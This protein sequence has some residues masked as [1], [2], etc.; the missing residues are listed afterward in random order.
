LAA[1]PRWQNPVSP[2]FWNDEKVRAWTDHAQLLALYLLTCPA[3]TGEGFY[4]LRLAEAS[5]DLGWPAERTRDAL[6]ELIRTDFADYDEGPRVVLIVKGLKYHPSGFESVKRPTEGNVRAIKG[7]LKALDGVQG[8]ARLFARFHV[9]AVR[10]QP[11][12]ARAISAHYRIA[13][14]EAG[15]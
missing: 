3:K 10:Y 5:D 7:A 4:H 8:S 12:L 9:S 6:D 11:A 14:P 2:T 15:P 13:L 1:H